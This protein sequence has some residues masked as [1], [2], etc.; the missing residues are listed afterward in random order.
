M[1]TWP[2]SYA[3]FDYLY[4]HNLQPHLENESRQTTNDQQN[5]PIPSLHQLSKCDLWEKLENVTEI[6]STPS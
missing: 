6:S 5:S 2:Y 3:P 4:H 1:K